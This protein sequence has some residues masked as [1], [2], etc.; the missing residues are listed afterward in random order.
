MTRSPALR[1][2]LT[3]EG[4]KARRKKAR[5][6]KERSKRDIR[7]KLTAGG[8]M[9]KGGIVRFIEGKKV[10]RDNP[11]KYFLLMAVRSTF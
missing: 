9:E 5:R 3:E 2:Q 4:R 8:A 6:K 11:I 1:E 7:K 10:K